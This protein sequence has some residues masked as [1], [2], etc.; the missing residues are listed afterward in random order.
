MS[1]PHSPTGFKREMRFLE[2]ARGKV[3]AVFAFVRRQDGGSPYGG[4]LGPE[5]PNHFEA[6]F[7][8]VEGHGFVRF[9]HAED[10]AL[11]ERLERGEIDLAPA[12]LTVVVV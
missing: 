6:G 9:E 11:G 10:V 4:V 3:Q 12:G 8:F 7:Q 1:I 2:I 5:T